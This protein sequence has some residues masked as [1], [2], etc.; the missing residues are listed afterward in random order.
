MICSPFELP[1]CELSETSFSRGERRRARDALGD[2]AKGG[3]GQPLSLVCCSPGSSSAIHSRSVSRAHK[4]YQPTEL[5]GYFLP[6]DRLAPSAFSPNPRSPS[7]FSLSRSPPLC[8]PTAVL[9]YKHSFLLRPHTT[10]S[11]SSFPILRSPVRSAMRSSFTLLAAAALASV[12]SAGVVQVDVNNL[13]ATT[14]NG[15][16]G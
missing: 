6:A 8:S 1:A 16:Y 2:D 4:P 3:V 7:H 13:P 15:Q 12:V 5:R 14:E 11:P 10:T 9:H